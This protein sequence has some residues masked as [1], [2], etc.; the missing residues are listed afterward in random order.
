MTEDNNTTIDIEKATL[1]Q[2]AA[3]EQSEKTPTY[4]V[5]YRGCALALLIIVITGIILGVSSTNNDPLKLPQLRPAPATTKLSNSTEAPITGQ[6]TS[7]PTL[8][9]VITTVPTSAPVK[10]TEAPISQTAPDPPLGLVTT[11]APTSAPVEATTAPIPAVMTTPT[12]PPTSGQLDV[13][14]FIDAK[15]AQGET[16]IIIPPGRHYIDPQHN[17]GKVHLHLQNLQDIVIDG[18]G[19]AEIV[20]TK[21]TRAITLWGCQNVTLKGLI[22]DYDP[23]PFS[24]GRIESISDDQLKL[25]VS[26]IDGYPAA[27]SLKETGKIEIYDSATDELTTPTYYGVTVGMADESGKNVIVTKKPNHVPLSA[28]KVGDIVVFG[29]SNIVNPIPHA[30]FAKDSAGLL[31]EGVKVYASNMFGFLENDCTSSGYIGSVVDRRLPEDDIKQRGYRRLR[32]AN[33]DAFHSK[34][35]PIGPRFQNIIARYNAD[36]GIAVNGHYHLISNVP[37]SLDNTIRVIGKNDEVP[38]L[39]EGDMVE[40][41]KYS[42]ERIENAKIVSFDSETTYA[43]DQAEKDFL[44]AQTFSGR[45]K[46]TNFATKVYTVTLDRAIDVPMGSLIASTNRLGNGFRVEDCIIGPNRARGMLLKASDGVVTGNIVQDTWLA[47]IMLAPEY[48]WL[49]AGS[50]TNLLIAN[51][52]ITRAHDVAIS[53]H[54]EGGDGTVAPAGAHGRIII[55]DNRIVDSSMPAIAVTSTSELF[56]FQ[57]T[58]EG[59]NND[60]VPGWKREDFG[61]QEDPGRQIYLENVASV[62]STFAE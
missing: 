56:L 9:L 40:L 3:L 48:S 2:K 14:A 35:A 30:I 47:G 15:V 31:F 32:S 38:N 37:S 52:T 44:G 26:M 12:L 20:C 53:V 45:V 19:E 18:M 7:A 55:E 8:G 36:D 41:V 34:H 33:A 51:N 25:T 61:R 39:S 62:R 11:T 5:F 17:N 42:G 46:L 16:H 22:V 23:L 50:G 10:A 58:I 24:Q 29:S 13:Q 28:E 4:T 1:E 57:N 43:L 54:A 27:D 60:Y 21:T 49:E 6:T 59:A